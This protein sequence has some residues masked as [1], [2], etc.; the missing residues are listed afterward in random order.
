ML[1]RLCN[2]VAILN[3]SFL[4]INLY[5][6]ISAHTQNIGPNAFIVTKSKK[7][8]R[9]IPVKPSKTIYNFGLNGGI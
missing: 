6:L 7:E 4:M 8:I 5:F 9:H 3:D 2:I 1:T